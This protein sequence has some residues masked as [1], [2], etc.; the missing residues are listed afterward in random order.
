MYFYEY[1]AVKFEKNIVISQTYKK[2]AS[3]FRA[4]QYSK[5]I[6][7]FSITRCLRETFIEKKKSS[8]KSEEIDILEQLLEIK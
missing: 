1:T 3:C 6:K 8:C 5:P 4:E 2:F 7:S